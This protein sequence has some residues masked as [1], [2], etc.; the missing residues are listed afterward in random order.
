MEEEIKCPCCG[1]NINQV[2]YKIEDNESMKWG[3]TKCPHCEEDIIYITRREVSFLS[4][5]NYYIDKD[6]Y[7]NDKEQAEPFND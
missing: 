4:P 3:T 6:G 1:E 5:K 2:K 7:I